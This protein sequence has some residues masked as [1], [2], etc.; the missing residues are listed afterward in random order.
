MKSNA[1]FSPSDERPESPCAR[2]AGV[3]AIVLLDAARAADFA[4]HL[5]SRAGGGLRV[6]PVVPEDGARA[7]TEPPAPGGR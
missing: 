6:V 2:A 5:E 4:R 1:S 3:S 7:W